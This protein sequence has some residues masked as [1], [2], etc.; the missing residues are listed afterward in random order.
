MDAHL[1]FIRIDGD[2]V[3]WG[4]VLACRVFFEEEHFVSTN[5]KS[6]QDSL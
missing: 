3:E 2:V 4:D 5:M 6:L 1:S